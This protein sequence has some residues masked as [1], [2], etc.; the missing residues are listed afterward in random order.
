VPPRRN[1]STAAA[2]RFWVGRTDGDFANPANWSATSGGS[3][4]ASVPTTRDAV[5]FDDK[6]SGECLIRGN[7][8]IQSI[9]MTSGSNVR[10]K[11]AAG[12]AL[13]L[14]LFNQ[15]GG[16]FA[17]GDAAMTVKSRFTL[18]GGKFS[19]PQGVLTLAEDVSMADGTFSPQTGTVLFAGAGKVIDAGNNTFHHV[20]VQLGNPQGLFN[21][22]KPL[23]VVDLTLNG[24]NIIPADIHVTGNV[25]TTLKKCS[26]TGVIVVRG[27]ADQTLS[28]AGASGALPGLRIEKSGGTLTLKDKICIDADNK[29]G[30]K[31]VSGTVKTEGSTVAVTGNR[32]TFDPGNMAF[33]NFIV[34]VGNPAAEFL[35]TGT[36]SINGSFTHVK[37]KFATGGAIVVAGRTLTKEE[38][39]SFNAKKAP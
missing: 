12:S 26:G 7:V 10:V 20:V 36:L 27:S 18:S 30:W 31:Y 8:T 1:D 4:G 6:G 17:G 11:Q 21:S 28:A 9:E 34:E 33:H 24:T 39:D 38:R 25:V 19:A 5:C 37:G 16:A 2:T 15:S 3:G 32:V 22:L 35:V 23:S 29:V 14:Q 13:N